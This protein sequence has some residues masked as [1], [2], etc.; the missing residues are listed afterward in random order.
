MLLI[1]AT[2]TASHA[3]SLFEAAPDRRGAAPTQNG[4][5]KAT[6]NRAGVESVARARQVVD[7]DDVPLAGGGYASFRAVPI[8]PFAADAQVFTF[9]GVTQQPIPRPDVSIYEGTD[10]ADPKRHLLLSIVGGN[11]IWAVV[12][13]D[14]AATTLILPADDAAATS[15]AHAV[16]DPRT[17]PP[18]SHPL[19]DGDKA[20]PGTLAP[21]GASTLAIPPSAD[22]PPGPP[23]AIEVLVDVGFDLFANRF[24]SSTTLAS[25]YAANVFGAVSAI[26][27]RDVNV[28]ILIKQLVIWTSA[29]PFSGASTSAQLTAYLNWNKANRSGVSRDVAH[30][31][32]NL[33]GAGGIAY[34]GVLCNNSFGYGVSN[35]HGIYS[36]FPSFGYLWDVQV[37]AHELGHN[38]GSPH[39]HCY[40]PPLDNCYNQEEGCYSGPVAASVGETMSYCHLSGGNGIEMG[41]GATVGGVI[42]STA[43]AANCV[44]SAPGTCG[45]GTV[46][47]GEQCDDGNVEDGDCCAAT[48]TF[49]GSS[50]PCADDGDP[51]TSDIC[52]N[53]SCAHV[54]PGT[55]TACQAATVIP[56]AGGTVIGVTFGSSTLTGTCGLTSVSPEQVFAW[57]P[58]H[59]GTA[60]VTTCN[61]ATNF[62]TVLYVR[63]A[64]C[65]VG[66]TVA[67]DDD[68]PCDSGSTKSTVAFSVSAGVTYYVVVD[69]YG[70]AQGDFGVEIIPPPVVLTPT[71]TTTL[72]TTPT[73]T[74][75]PTRTPTRTPTSTPTSTVTRTDTPTRTPTSTAT[76]TPTRTDTPTRTP[77][78]T[79]TSTPTSTSTRTDTPTRTPTRTATF[80]ATHTP[81]RTGTSTRTGTIT[82]TSTSTPTDSPTQT[83]SRT[84]TSTVTTTPTRTV[85]ITA[86]DT[87]TQTPTATPTQTATDTPTHTAT[88]TATDTPTQTPSATPTLTATFTA[89]HTET[90]TP[91]PISTAT[92]SPTATPSLP[93]EVALVAGAGRPGGTVCL[94]A[95]LATSGMALAATSNDLAYEP[96][97][98]LLTGC[99]L[100]AD[101]GSGTAID[102]TLTRTTPIEGTEHIQVAG[103]SAAIPSGPL[104]SCT[105]AVPPATT[106]GHYPIANVA[107]ATDVDGQAVVGMTGTAAM[108]VISTCAGDCDGDGMIDSDDLIKCINA[109][110]GQPLCSPSPQSAN[111]PIADVD[112]D[113]IISLGEVAQCVNSLLSGCL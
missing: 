38:A 3:V 50:T 16:L 29:D 82:P 86:T 63:S 107:A 36:T 66:S 55:C 22:A 20:T 71:P 27:R 75:T 4:G 18:P 89:T 109:Y 105:L 41:F 83:P 40:S 26:Y 88:A 52:A 80:T 17:A 1:A 10:A 30:L 21:L 19:C 69:G 60:T 96:A 14:G 12:R 33:S 25:A 35:L 78:R 108:V 112:L 81:T 103:G 68:S 93:P 100:N 28:A 85:T 64:S 15:G 77:T 92:Q 53:G 73:R 70:G 101:L 42:R 62:D 39:T 57:T 99:T 51:C 98:L 72:T 24:A 11:T 5:S 6:I 46:E 65:D 87:A 104:Y 23:L 48:C 97:N 106:P 32:A 84:P 13:E 34:L 76:E 110:L 31:I 49:E 91:T 54:P 95:Q 37:T 79:P 56:P 113:G 47:T 43:V 90:A 59:S 102:K 2:A 45:N 94:V 44:T 111:C 8:D 9:N 61:A 74:D 7:L 58:A 67:C